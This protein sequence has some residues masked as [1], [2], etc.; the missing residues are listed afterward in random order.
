M[1]SIVFVFL[2]FTFVPELMK[3]KN[4]EEINYNNC[5]WTNYN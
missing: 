2:I 5:I 1:L 4:N 3:I